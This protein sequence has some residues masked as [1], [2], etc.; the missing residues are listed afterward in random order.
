[1]STTNVQQTPANDGK[2]KVQIGAKSFILMVCILLAVVIVAGILTYVIPAGKYYRFEYIDDVSKIDAT[3]NYWVYTTNQD[4]NGQ[5]VKGSYDNRYKYTTDQSLVDAQDNQDFFVYTTDL[6]KKGQVVPD[7]YTI[8]TKGSTTRLPVWRWLTAPFESIIWG[9]T[10][11]PF[12]GSINVNEISI[13]ALLLVLGGTFK[14][15]E[16]SGGLEAFVRLI[17]QKLYTK[18]FVAVWA[19]TFMVMVLSAVFGLQEQLLILYPLLAM[20]C[21]AMNWS[22]FTAI[23]FILM[24]SGVGFTTAITNPLTIGLA[25]QNAGVQI[26]DGMWY[27]IIIFVVMYVVTSLYMTYLCKRDEKQATQMADISKFIV[28]DPVQKRQDQKKA[29]LVTLL[30]GIALLGVIIAVAIEALRSFSMIIMGVAFIVGTVIVGRILLGG[31]KP[32]GKAFLEGAKT[33]A[34]SL[35]IIVIAFAVPYIAKKGDILDTIFHFFYGI[36]TGSSPYVAVLVLYAFILILEFFIPSASAKAVLIIPMLTL[37]PIE[38]L[39]KNVILLTYLF[40]DGYTNVLFPTCGTLLIGLG[41]ADQSLGT[42]FKRTILFQL[43]LM[44]LSVGF[45]F[46]A[47]TIGV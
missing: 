1:M 24:T 43:L 25:S 42:W 15:L 13:I 6:N 27:R 41:L 34:P 7:S 45:I 22:K 10:D 12:P 9:N 2:T 20:L 5:V 17:I 19:I 14:V 4:L 31:F 36:V 35:L 33:I 28:D 30:F 29:L 21:S 16:E 11:K 26:T 47:I 46:L 18:R 32:M 37:A 40:A 44:A 39:S 3:E 38:G 8:L 23:S